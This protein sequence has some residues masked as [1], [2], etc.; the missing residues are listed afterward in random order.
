MSEYVDFPKSEIRSLGEVLGD[1]YERTRDF[2]GDIAT[3]TGIVYQEQQPTS[4]SQERQKPA[5]GAGSDCALPV[6]SGCGRGGP[7]VLKPGLR[8]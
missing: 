5:H 8:V 4:S 7:Q 2:I 1:L 3:A 6:C